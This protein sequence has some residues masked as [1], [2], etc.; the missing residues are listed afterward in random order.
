MGQ[1]SDY[2]SQLVLEICSIST[3]SVVCV[4]RLVPNKTNKPPFIDWYCI[5]G[6][7]G[8]ADVNTIR[9]QYHKLALQLHPDKNKHPKAEIAFKLLSEAY[10]CLSDAAKRKAFNLERSKSL[11]I[12]CNRIPSNSNNN[13]GSSSSFK[14]SR[15]SSISS[16]SRSCKLWRNINDIRESLRE[17]AKVIEKCLRVN[18]SMPTKNYDDDYMHRSRGPNNNNNKHRVEKETPVFNPS[19]YL[20][21]GYP[22]R[23]NHVNKDY[24]EKFWYLQQETNAVQSNNYS[25]GGSDKFS[26]SVFEAET[27]RSMFSRKFGPIPSQC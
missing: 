24:S 12:E 26:S 5:L 8:N 17:E 22:H 27:Q 9:K 15:S 18:N 1:E 11:C 14:S 19:N 10:A 2:K 3:R 6:V 7:A 16:S 20:Y 23:R 4:H 13:N 21:Q 25:K